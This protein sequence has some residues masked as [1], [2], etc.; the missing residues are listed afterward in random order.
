VLR[1]AV[2]DSRANASARQ[3]LAVV[4]GLKGNFEEATRLARADL[5]A[6]VADGNIAY[7]RDM[8]TQPA[9]WKQMETLDGKTAQVSAT[10]A[11]STP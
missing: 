1:K 8:L 5:P 2:G 4:L 7:L 3:N 9:L 11:T 6:D 10:P